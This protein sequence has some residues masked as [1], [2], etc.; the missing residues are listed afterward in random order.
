MKKAVKVYVLIT[1]L[2]FVTLGATVAGFF[3]GRFIDDT[4]NLP[5]VFTMIGFAASL[6]LNAFFVYAF[7]KDQK[8][9]K[10]INSEQSNEVSF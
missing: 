9:E 4:S 2:I 8:R 1:Q 7:H 10:K 3:I 5:V 6:V